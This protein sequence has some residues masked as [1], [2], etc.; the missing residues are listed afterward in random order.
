MKT[1]MIVLDYLSAKVHIYR[2]INNGDFDEL[3]AFVLSK[4]HHL[5]SCEWMCYQGLEVIEEDCAQEQKSDNG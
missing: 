5:G 3:E 2:N 1:D 4:G